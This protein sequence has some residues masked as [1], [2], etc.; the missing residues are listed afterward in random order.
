[1][2]TKAVLEGKDPLEWEGRTGLLSAFL[3]T[4]GGAAYPGVLPGYLLPALLRH[5]SAPAS[6]TPTPSLTPGSTSP[7]NGIELALQS[8]E[9]YCA[10]LP[11]PIETHSVVT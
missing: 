8:A 11:L 7:A 6:H 2:F 5:H 4:A 1:M 3:P 10:L 9:Q